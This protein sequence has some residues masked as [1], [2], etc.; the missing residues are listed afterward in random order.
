MLAGWAG[1][2]Q[3]GASPSRSSIQY[4]VNCDRLIQTA[5]TGPDIN[6]KMISSPSNRDFKFLPADGLRVLPHWLTFRLLLASSAESATEF[7]VSA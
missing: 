4:L 2:A 3:P 6:I 1:Y 7:E 5:V